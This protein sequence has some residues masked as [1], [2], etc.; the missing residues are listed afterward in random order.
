MSLASALSGVWAGVILTGLATGAV[1]GPTSLEAQEPRDT[2]TFYNAEV[3]LVFTAGN[4]TANTFGLG[5]GVR[6]V[7]ESSE[8]RV[9]VG[10]LRTESGKTMRVAVGTMSDFEVFDTTDAEL[11]AENYFIRSRYDRSVS[12]RFFLFGGGG[13]E[14]N[15]FAGLAG[16]VSFVGG[17]GN[18]WVDSD[19]TRLKTDY[20]VTYTI[21][22][23]VIEDPAKGATFAGVRA[24]WDFWRQLTGTTAFASAL[25]IDENLNNTADFR[26]D[27]TNSLLMDISEVLAFRASFQLLYDHLPSLAA[28][29]LEQPVGTPTGETV[30]APLD[31]LDTV[32]TVALVADFR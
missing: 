28:V 25:Q 22:N 12:D 15:T 16:R 17:A 19:G 3:T 21:Q 32:F 2:G 14:R 27:L 31:K 18:T 23:D 20:G 5:A 4:A 13:W 11:T 9:R 30:L 10:G 6:R 26:A 24:A 7:R 29:A 8:F 1:G